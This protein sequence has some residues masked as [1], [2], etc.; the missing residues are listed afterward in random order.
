MSNSVASTWEQTYAF[1]TA[2]SY[3]SSPTPSAVGANAVLTA[4]NVAIYAYNQGFLY[5]FGVYSPPLY[6]NPSSL[7][8]LLLGGSSPA[9]GDYAFAAGSWVGVLSSTPGTT[10]IVQLESPLASNTAALVELQGY[11]V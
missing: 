10:L 4:I 1:S 8:G 6:S 5:G 9:S 3:A 2:G 7:P 11:F